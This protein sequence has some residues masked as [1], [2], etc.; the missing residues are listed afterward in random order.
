MVAQKGPLQTKLNARYMPLSVGEAEQ[1]AVSEGWRE[2]LA[3]MQRI[4]ANSRYF[5][6]T[7][8]KPPIDVA[9]GNCAVGMCIDFYGRQQEEAI[10]RRGQGEHIGYATP[11]GGSVSSVDPIALMRGAPNREAAV[12]FIEFV[13][14]MEGQKLWNFRSGTPEGPERYALRRLPVRRD[15]YGPEYAGYRSDP[16]AEP[17]AGQEQL[18]YRP[19]WTSGIFREMSFVIRVMCLDTH[20]ELARAW[21]AINEAPLGR[22]AEALAVLQNLDAVSYGQ[23]NGL[24]KQALNARDKTEEIRLARELGEHF[25]RQYAEAERIAR[26]GS[27]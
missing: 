8:Q 18:V 9:A 10:R 5:T 15:F 4:G 27:R 20:T 12:A 23:V 19:A 14:S 11:I 21:R 17:Y 6:D 1:L 26:S 22:R 3:L 24:I 7:S 13:L 16:E 25:R 2:G